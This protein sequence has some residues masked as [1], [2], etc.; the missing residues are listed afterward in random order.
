LGDLGNQPVEFVAVVAPQ[1]RRRESRIV[2][3]RRPIQRLAQPAQKRSDNTAMMI[4]PS[5]AGK[6]PR[7][8]CWDGSIPSARDPRR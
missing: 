8:R 3:K 6:L 7:A 1:G 4:E 2:G 5:E